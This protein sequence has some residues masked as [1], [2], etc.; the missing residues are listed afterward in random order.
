M[1]TEEH[2]DW[3]EQIEKLI[4]ETIDKANELR[5]LLTISRFLALQKIGPI[6][7]Q[8][9]Q[10]LKEKPI[11]EA[12]THLYN[13]LPEPKRIA[14][15]AFGN[16]GA[17]REILDNVLGKLNEV[18]NETAKWPLHPINW[19]KVAAA[20]PTREELSFL[21]EILDALDNNEFFQQILNDFRSERLGWLG[22]SARTFY[23]KRI[24]D[25]IENI[26]GIL[27]GKAGRKEV[28]ARYIGAEGSL[29]EMLPEPT[30]ASEAHLLDLW[31]EVLKILIEEF[32]D[33]RGFM[34]Y[35][36]GI[37]KQF[38]NALRGPNRL[39]GLREAC[40][41][42]GELYN[43]LPEEKQKTYEPV[44]RRFLETALCDS[45]LLP[46]FRFLAYLLSKSMIKY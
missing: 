16:A 39:E 11:K 14:L 9:R 41:E 27:S 30:E 34:K 5:D 24:V 35:L 19:G 4:R 40:K 21:E 43:L 20:I 17:A 29:P 3:N 26:V 32:K 44:F 38:A 37:V 28:A 36:E 10:Q 6:S 33:K 46:K 13:E 1:T 15:E 42:I 22:E 18:S 8:L 23:I 45:S 7:P 12:I 31:G 2:F 25:R